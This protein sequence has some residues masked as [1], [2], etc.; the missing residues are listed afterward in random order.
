MFS[1]SIVGSYKITT[2]K[3]IPTLSSFKRE[4][5]GYS[6]NLNKAKPK[7]KSV[8]H[9]VSFHGS[10]LW[11]RLLQKGWATSLDPPSAAHSLPSSL[12]HDAHWT[13]F[14]KALG[15]LAETL[16]SFHPLPFLGLVQGL[17]CSPTVPRLSRLVCRLSLQWCRPLFRHHWSTLHPPASVIPVK[18]SLTLVT[19]VSY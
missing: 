18:H 15:A 7:R 11:S 13:G 2:K 8:N 14:S 6:H 10:Y 12:R 4:E 16:L 1:L 19:L 5:P 9:S 17:Q 3:I